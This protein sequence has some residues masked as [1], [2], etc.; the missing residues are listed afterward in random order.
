MRGA[1]DQ[2]PIVVRGAR[3]QGVW[4]FVVGAIFVA[5][6]FVILATGKSTGTAIL[7]IGFFGLIAVLGLVMLVSPARLEIGP[8][9]I[10][11]K[12]LWRTTALAWGDV[13]YFRPVQVMSSRTVG[14]DYVHGPPPGRERVARMSMAASGAQGALPAGWEVGPNR[15]A[16]M[17]NQARNR[18]IADAGQSSERPAQAPIPQFRSVGLSPLST[19]LTGGRLD[20]KTYW[21]AVGA[22]FALGV[23][24]QLLV[25]E[26]IG[27]SGMATFLF[28]R[29][30][31]GRL[32][33]LG[34][35]P[36][37]QLAVWALVIEAAILFGVAKAP[38]NMAIGAAILVQMVCTLV[39]GLI[40]GASGEN[41]YGPAPGR[42]SPLDV[43]ETFR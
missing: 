18:W 30:F 24:L 41:R 31:G 17:L 36:W 35:S 27:L 14:F 42:P 32:K 37:W 22:V 10:T 1:L 39:L 25:G 19:V 43:A 16:D 34:K 6:G 40:P 3:S 21:I 2:P 29:I 7:T 8:S 38:V 20:R 12:A 9:G 15:L 4:L 28:I 5:G 11:Q 26:R 23:A 33:D 13:H